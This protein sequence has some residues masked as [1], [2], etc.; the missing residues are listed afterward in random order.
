M[1]LGAWGGTTRRFRAQIDPDGLETTYELWM[2]DPCPESECIRIVPL[3]SG[4]IPATEDPAEVSVE[5]ASVPEALIA[6][7]GKYKYW[8][9]VRN[10]AGKAK[11]SGKLK[12][13]AQ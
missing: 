7:A 3:A 9:V 5:L 4:V 12:T 1:A 10:S 13:L 6:P 8:L 11:R 2:D